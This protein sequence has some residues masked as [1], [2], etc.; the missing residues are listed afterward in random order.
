MTR[1]L[2]VLCG[3]LAMMLEPA[4][5]DTPPAANKVKR[6][7]ELTRYDP[8]TGS[9]SKI[10]TDLVDIEK[11]GDIT[12]VKFT[13]NI[14]VVVAYITMYRFSHTA[15]E[16][17]NGGQLTSFKSQTDDNGTKH[18]IT[19]STTGDKTHL[20][21]DG[22]I[23][24]EPH[25]VVPGSFWSK[26]LIP[27]GNVFSEDD[28]KIS[29]VKVSDLGEETLTLNGTKHQTHHYRTTGAAEL[30]RDLWFE[31]DVMLRL[32]LKGSDRSKI[33]SDLQP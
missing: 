28:G 6:V 24:D 10:G 31:G 25:K 4:L 22:K 17:W 18:T 32:Q 12:T 14:K 1:K 30:E 21:V 16:V 33:V 23:T 2:A 20:E 26:A 13:T 9:G 8:I 7:Y 5:A 3:L 11:Q 29:T 27:T 15:V 19:V